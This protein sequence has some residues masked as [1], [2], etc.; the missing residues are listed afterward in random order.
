MNN[1]AGDLLHRAL[2]QGVLRGHGVQPAI[3][4]RRTGGNGLPSHLIC[5]AD[6]RCLSDG[7]MVNQGARD[8]HGAEAVGGDITSRQSTAEAPAQTTGTSYH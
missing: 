5:D 2:F 8:R 4:E 3:F 6:H 7:R 1:S